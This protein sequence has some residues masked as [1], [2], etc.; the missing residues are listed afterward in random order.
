[1]LVLG[2]LGMP[3][4]AG[5]NKALQTQ[6]DKTSYCI[7][8]DMAR[9]FKRQGRQVDPDLLMRG[10]QEASAG[11]KLL[12]SEPEMDDL[13]KVYMAETIRKQALAKRTPGEENAEKGQVFLAGNKVRKDVVC[14]PS[15][16]QYQVLKAGTGRKPAASDTV[17]C[18]YRGTQLDGK[19]FIAANLEKPATFKVAGALV[20]AFTEALPLM[21][22]G[23]KWKLFV[24][25]HLAFGVRGVG[26]IVGPNETVIFELELA[27]I[28]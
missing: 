3:G 12:L 22:V 28:K 21:P 27:G 15:G 17:E 2:L 14:L 19:E 16:L 7:G 18:R 20:P 6:E 10:F 4:Q 5:E 24:P 26:R 8:V 13:R 11:A 23:S 25:P 1:M 9:N